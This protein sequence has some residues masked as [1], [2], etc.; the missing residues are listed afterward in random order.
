[1]SKN[2]ISNSNQHSSRELLQS[3]TI[4]KNDNNNPDNTNNNN[5]TNVFAQILIKNPLPIST[6]ESRIN[7]TK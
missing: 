7:N 1:V 3:A 4:I 6:D 2:T 5:N